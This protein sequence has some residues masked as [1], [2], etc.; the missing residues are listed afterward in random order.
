MFSALAA[1]GDAMF[2]AV[3]KGT[4][5]MIRRVDRGF[6]HA[7]QPTGRHFTSTRQLM[8]VVGTPTMSGTL[9]VAEGQPSLLK[10][11]GPVV[12]GAHHAGVTCGKAA[13][14]CFPFVQ[15]MCV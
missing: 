1:H 9:G 15:L 10:S 6:W 8:Q 2:G 12:A 11:V 4:S 3:G 13:S 14:A 5:V 7:V